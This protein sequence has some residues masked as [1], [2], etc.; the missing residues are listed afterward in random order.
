M[1]RKQHSM[2]GKDNLIL[3]YDYVTIGHVQF[4]SIALHN[5]D[6]RDHR[7]HCARKFLIPIYANLFSLGERERDEPI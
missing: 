3:K 7:T 5:L 6:S 4:Q 2:T 1:K